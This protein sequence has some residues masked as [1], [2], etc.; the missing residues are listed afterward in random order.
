MANHH[1]PGRDKG[2]NASWLNTT[3]SNLPQ[4]CKGKEVDHR[5]LFIDQ[6]SYPSEHTYPWRRYETIFNTYLS[7][8]D[9][10][11]GSKQM[12]KPSNLAERIIR[13]VEAGGLASSS[14]EKISSRPLQI[15][16]ARVRA[17]RQERGMSLAEV[18]EQADID[19]DLL[20][21]TELGVASPMQVYKNLR[22]LGNALG[23]RYPELSRLLIRTTLK[24]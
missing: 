21:A 1:T 9:Q 10:T 23:D 19:E 16:G 22:T 17:L 5:R 7:P 2:M 20:L 15:L 24:M 3:Q 12:N 14:G 13:A 11:N 18:S 4:P 6:P 8:Q